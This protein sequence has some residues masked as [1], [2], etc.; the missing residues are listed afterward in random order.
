M[1]LDSVEFV[2]C[3]CSRA[4][5]LCVRRQYWI[6]RFDVKYVCDCAIQPSAGAFK[7]Y[8]SNLYR[9]NWNMNAKP[10]RRGLADWLNRKKGNYLMETSTSDN[11][12]NMI[13]IFRVFL[14]FFLALAF[15]FVANRLSLDSINNASYEI[16]VC[17]A[18]FFLFVLFASSFVLLFRIFHLSFRFSLE[19]KKRLNKIMG[20]E[21]VENNI[22]RQIQDKRRF[23]HSTQ[24]NT[25]ARYDGVD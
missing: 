24:L 4:R 17:N 15:A 9:K 3:R 6:F 13:T 20:Y 10:S 25:P 7:S 8:H 19:T 11:N 12:S 22:E 16:S 18:Q 14:Y 23:K 1:V 2:R 5:K 21:A